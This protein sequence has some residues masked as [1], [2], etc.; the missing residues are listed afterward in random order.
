MQELIPLKVF[1]FYVRLS[2]LT[3]KSLIIVNLANSEHVVKQ[4]FLI[5]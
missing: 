4:K 2:K 5:L 1:N 3:I